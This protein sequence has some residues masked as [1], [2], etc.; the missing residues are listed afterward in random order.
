MTGTSSIPKFE[1]E[2]EGEMRKDE[3]QISFGPCA[4]ITAGDAG[5]YTTLFMNR[6]PDNPGY[7]SS[8][9]T[10]VPTAILLGNRN[11]WEVRVG[12]LGGRLDGQY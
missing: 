4:H 11:A 10:R 1:S 5:G 12:S 9:T 8:S 2:V 7:S 3:L 6:F